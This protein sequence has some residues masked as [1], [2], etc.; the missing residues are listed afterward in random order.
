MKEK[1]IG[2]IPVRLAS[3]RLPNKALLPI[4]NFPLIVTACKYLKNCV[5]IKR[6]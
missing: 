3:K 4:A 5:K 1:I 2:L 6:K